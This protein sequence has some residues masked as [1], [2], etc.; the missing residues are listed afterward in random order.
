MPRSIAI[1]I[2]DTDMHTL[3]YSALRH[4]VASFDFQ[5]VIVF[6]DRPEAWPGFDVILVPPL[7]TI[8]DYNLL[9]CRQ[10][11]SFL[12][13]DSVLVIQ[14]D[15]FI[16]NPNE[17]SPLFNH[18]DY[19]GAPWPQ[20]SDGFDVGNGGFSLR[21]QKLVEAVARLSY[22]DPLEAEDIFIGRTSRR[23]LESIG[24][25]FPSRSIASHFS[26]EFPS[27][28]WPTFGFHGVFHLPN[29]YRNALD[30]LIDG[31]SDRIIRTRANYLL[32][33]IKLISHDAAEKFQRR[34]A[35]VTNG[36]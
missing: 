15:G 32:P 28:P 7:R 10:L 24:L 35:A 12:R 5:Q 21:S 34:I 11:P 33:T 17:F 26:V 6:S 29:V 27:V 4:S 3:A 36:S 25:R 2:V 16:L 20:F 19:I 31:L 14:Y 22:D 30:F 18:Y 23:S 1:A 8:E 13:C 9:I